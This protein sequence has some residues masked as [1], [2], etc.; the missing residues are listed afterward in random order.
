[1]STA[2]F[3]SPSKSDLKL[4]IEVAKKMNIKTRILKID[5]LEDICLA[6]A[7]ESG[8]TGSHIDTE[9]YLKKMTK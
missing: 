4:L 2:I 3:E 7:V 8:K 9:K 6:N 1:M 5:E